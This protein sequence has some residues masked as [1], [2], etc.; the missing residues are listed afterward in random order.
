MGK[1]GG[2]S[3]ENPK[4]AAARQKQ[5]ALQEERDRKKALED[6]RKEAAEWNVGSNSRASKR[7]EGEVA[8]DLCLPS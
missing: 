8:C 6:E 1:K 4:V 3:G 5:E 2:G 7:A